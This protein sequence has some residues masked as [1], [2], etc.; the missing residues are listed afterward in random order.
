MLYD[1]TDFFQSFSVIFVLK[2]YD[3]EP[4]KVRKVMKVY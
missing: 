1:T 4:T 3:I 2:K